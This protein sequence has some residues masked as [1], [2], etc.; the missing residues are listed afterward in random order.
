MGCCRKGNL[1]AC[2]ENWNHTN[3]KLKNSTSI[4]NDDVLKSTRVLHKCHISCQANEQRE[5]LACAHTCAS[6][7]IC[8]CIRA[9]IRQ[10]SGDCE[11]FPNLFTG[12]CWL[13]LW[14]LSAFFLNAMFPLWSPF[15]FFFNEL[16]YDIEV[17]IWC[18]WEGKHSEFRDFFL[19]W[20]VS[21]RQ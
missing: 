16:P 2:C 19:S 12:V 8:I 4:P 5:R 21:Q 14:M 1:W 7:H 20:I 11:T 6:T 9:N 13:S 15:F 3:H 17:H 18:F 10:H